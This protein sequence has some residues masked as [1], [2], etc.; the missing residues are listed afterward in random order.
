MIHLQG[1]SHVHIILFSISE[2][3]I[4]C[5]LVGKLGL[6]KDTSLPL[7]KNKYSNEK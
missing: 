1:D 3:H 5:C 4:S 2:Y 7:N 6:A